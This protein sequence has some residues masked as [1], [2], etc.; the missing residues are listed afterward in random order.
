MTTQADK[1]RT[2]RSLNV[3]GDL[4]WLKLQPYVLSSAAAR[5]NHKLSFRYFGPYPVESRICQVAYKLKLPESNSMYSV[6]HI[7]LL[8]KAIGSISVTSYL[9]PSDCPVMQVLEMV[10]MLDS[11]LKSKGRRIINQVLIKWVG[12]PAELATWEDE[13]QVRHMLP[14]GTACRQAVIEERGDVTDRLLAGNSDSS[15][16]SASSGR[17]GPTLFSAGQN[18]CSPRV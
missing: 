17:G 4:V 1:H 3:G 13:D 9:L 15:A 16:R 18:G 7:W 5:A 14:A 12:C 11:R 2:E 10:Y 6:L 8:K